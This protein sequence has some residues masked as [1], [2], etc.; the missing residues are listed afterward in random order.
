MTGSRTPARG[1][2]LL[3][4]YAPTVINGLARGLLL[5]ILPLFA[6]EFSDSYATVGLILAAG[7]GGNLAADLPV[8]VLIRRLGRKRV[9]LAGGLV[10]SLSLLGLWW[11][12]S[13][14]E[15]VAVQFA[16]GIGTAMWNISR[17]SFLAEAIRS[18]R[19]GRASAFMGGI[20][21]VT[22]FFTPAA[23][24]FL[25]AAF[26]LRVPFLACAGLTFLALLAAA[27]WIPGDGPERTGRSAG[28]RRRGVLLQMIREH[29]AIVP[30]CAAH[31]CVSLIRSARNVLI[32]LYGADQLGLGA[33]DIGVVTSLSYSVDMLMFYP[34][35]LLMDRFGRKFASVPSFLVQAVGIA[36][37]PLTGSFAGLAA[38]AILIG[39]GNGIGSGT[40]LTLGS[41]LAPGNARA[42]FLGV[43]RFIG[44]AGNAGS[45]LVVGPV[46]DLL[47]LTAAP[48]AV[49][50]VGVAAAAILLLGVPETLVPASVSRRT[51]EG[52]DGP[53]SQGA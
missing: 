49:S 38:V 30:A 48:V 2:L 16:G 35:G 31:L 28:G 46:A 19:R 18:D 8:G 1:S 25:A 20:N 44:D 9:M 3:A 13:V 29:N 24:G 27:R 22:S 47:G 11:V 15:A 32:P 45:P 41:D 53:G 40:M 39:F 17:H 36:A 50:G 42:E 37:I 5:P 21:R 52:A 12:E 43:W 26:G 4:L 33:A 7:A 51:N 23:G 6:G 10:V 14:F 34:A